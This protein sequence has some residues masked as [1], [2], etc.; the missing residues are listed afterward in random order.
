[1]KTLTIPLTSERR[2]MLQEALEKNASEITISFEEKSEL[3]ES[4]LEGVQGGAVNADH[5]RASRA[6]YIAGEL[7]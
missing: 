7:H 2:A 6:V 4:D 5:R 3:S 1:M